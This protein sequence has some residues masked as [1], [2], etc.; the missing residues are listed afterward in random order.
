VEVKVRGARL[1]IARL[2]GLL[3][4]ADLLD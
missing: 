2:F 1:P 3:D 4:L